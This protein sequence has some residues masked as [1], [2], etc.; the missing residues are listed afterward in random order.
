MYRRILCITA[1]L[2]SVCITA[3]I[4]ADIE[5]ADAAY[6]QGDFAT[7]MAEA[8]AP[9]TVNTARGQFLLGI[10]YA[11]GQGVERDKARALEHFR[12]SEALGF[13][14]AS[15]ALAAF[16]IGEGAAP[17]AAGQAWIIDDNGE[18][19]GST[20]AVATTLSAPPASVPSSAAPVAATPPTRAPVAA[21]PVAARAP[22][23][24][25]R[26]APKPAAPASAIN[27]NDYVLQLGAFGGAAAA[28]KEWNRVRRTAPDL[29]TDLQ[30][31]Y[32]TVEIRGRTYHRL[33]VGPFSD[34]AGANERCA[35]LKGNGALRGCLVRR[36]K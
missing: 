10:M 14:P 19:A 31:A 33:W 11:N 21:T 35:A 8:S 2:C 20:D 4:Q 15:D 1:T 29:T 36:G 28:E 25:A 32:P 26:A 6:D 9:D 23:L 18:R 5:R 7:A 13:S 24:P 22:S 30:A 16:G 34:K 12:Q 3:P 27:G 17:T